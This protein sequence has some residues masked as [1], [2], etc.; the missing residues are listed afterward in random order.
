MCRGLER[1]LRIQ[2]HMFVKLN[3]GHD[4]SFF[5]HMLSLFCRGAGGV[6]ASF[7]VGEPGLSVELQRHEA[8]TS[9]LLA[10][11]LAVQPHPRFP[12]L[13]DSGLIVF[14]PRL[15]LAFNQTLSLFSTCR[16]TGSSPS[17]NLCS[18]TFFSLL[19][20][21]LLTFILGSGL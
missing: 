7:M 12:C 1:M 16:E 2:S 18:Q 11:I 19:Y 3:T 6:S 14:L 13:D 5:P 21:Y 4:F 8:L 20:F 10:N 9:L 15:R 17:C